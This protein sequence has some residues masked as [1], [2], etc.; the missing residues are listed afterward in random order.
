[1]ASKMSFKRGDSVTHYFEMPSDSWTA[2]GTLTFIAKPDVDDDVADSA[3][4]I[5]RSFDDTVAVDD[6]E[7]VTYTCAFIPSDTNNIA[8]NGENSAEYLGEFQYVNGSSVSTFPG[9]DDF[10]Q[11]TV[12]FDLRRSGA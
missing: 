1:M 8:S 3:A 4:V 5:V 10:I 6:G 2:G 7:L 9:N 12:Y 11:V